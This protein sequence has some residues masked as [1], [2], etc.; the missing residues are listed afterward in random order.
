VIDY[1]AQRIDR[2]LDAARALVRSLDEA[3]L[4]EGRRINRA[5]AARLLE[6]LAYDGSPG[7]ESDES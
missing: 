3:A 7:G 5:L 4:A 2:S 1:I 6:R